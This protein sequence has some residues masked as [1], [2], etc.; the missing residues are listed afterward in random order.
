MVTGVPLGPPAPRVSIHQ[1]LET[2][3]DTVQGAAWTWPWGICPPLAAPTSPCSTYSPCHHESHQHRGSPSTV[4]IVVQA[5]YPALR[6]IPCPWHSRACREGAEHQPGQA[7]TAA[8]AKLLPPSESCGHSLC[9]GCPTPLATWHPRQWCR[10]MCGAT[11]PLPHRYSLRQGSR[12]RERRLHLWLRSRT[13]QR[14][15]ISIPDPCRAE[16]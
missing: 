5:L 10:G 15:H 11:V 4:R 8:V 6:V 13:Q 16:G 12:E 2:P 1:V 14:R 7:V 3:W 9:V